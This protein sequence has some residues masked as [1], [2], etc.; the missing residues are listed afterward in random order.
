MKA[1][2]T[3]FVFKK[4]TPAVVNTGATEFPALGETGAAEAGKKKKAEVKKEPEDPCY[5]REKEFFIYDFDEV[6]NVC[7]CSPEQLGFV[8]THYPDHYFIPIDILGWLYEMAVYREQA[9]QDNVYN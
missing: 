7:I 6:A 3:D 1:T 4:K 2:S 9:E 5:G 8:A